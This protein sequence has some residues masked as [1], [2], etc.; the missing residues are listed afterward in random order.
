MLTVIVNKDSIKNGEILIEDKGECNHIQNV[1]RLK[2]GDVLRVIDGEF[3]YFTE[4]MEMTKGK[5]VLKIR[6]KIEDRYSNEMEINI[7]LG[8]LKNDKMN[9]AIQKL[10]E[11]GINE[12]IPM[13]TTRTVVKLNEKKEKWETVIK[14]SLKQCKGVKFTKIHTLTK[15]K[16][17]DYSQYD[18][19]LYA[20]ENSEECKKI[21]EIVKGRNNK[22]LY[23]IGPE[24][25]FTEEEV[26]FL[27][28]K[29][30]IEINL[31][32]RILRAETAAIVLGGILVNL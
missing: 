27:R 7:A 13:E 32:K 28:E 29:G 20:Y 15:L 18:K 6:D 24:G 4:I 19:V 12:I 30:A 9:L 25:G 31:G 17:I 16:N 14:E 1:F 11:I 3:E 8:I 22:I 10:T 26:E 21:S 5:V 23:L 2:I